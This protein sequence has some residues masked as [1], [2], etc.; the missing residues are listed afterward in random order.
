[1]RFTPRPLTLALILFLTGLAIHSKSR[2]PNSHYVKPKGHPHS[3]SNVVPKYTGALYGLLLKEM[4][5]E[6]RRMCSFA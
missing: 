3:P 5:R 6:K 2:P 4:V 1:M